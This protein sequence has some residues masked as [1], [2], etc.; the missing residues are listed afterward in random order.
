LVFNLITKKYIFTYKV[1]PN[2]LHHIAFYPIKSFDNSDTAIILQGPVIDFEF[3]YLSC[4]YYLNTFPG[5]KI[6]VSTWKDEMSIKNSNKL[7]DINVDVIASD[8]PSSAGYKHFNYQLISTKKAIE[9]INLVYGSQYILK[10]RVDQR[11]YN[12]NAIFYLKSLISQHS[13]D[14]PKIVACSLNTFKSRLYAVSDMFLFGNSQAMALYWSAPID[15]RD[16]NILHNKIVTAVDHHEYSRVNVCEQYLVTNYS[17][18]MGDALNWSQHDYEICL[19]KYFVIIDKFTLDLV[20]TK[21]SYSE[22][23]WANY[24]ESGALL[25]YCLNDWLII[26]N[27]YL[28]KNHQ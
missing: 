27:D 12:P 5:V 10:S 20:W 25:E 23:L 3:L 13:S 7:I 21:Y 11:F 26:R 24:A 4:Q 17:S 9:H 14:Y 16:V 19:A 1:R 22:D 15:T 8:R 2:N 18:T 6:V 28:K